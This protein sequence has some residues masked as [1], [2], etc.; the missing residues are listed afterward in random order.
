MEEQGLNVDQ[1]VIERYSSAAAAREAALCCPVDNPEYLKVIPR[2]VIAKDYGCGD[3]SQWVREGETVLDLGSGTGKICFIASQ[4][5]GAGGR[6]IGVDM[7][8]D[9]LKVAREAAPVVAERI[10]YRNVEFLKG[11]IDDLRLNTDLFDSWLTEHPVKS[12]ADFQE[13]RRYMEETRLSRPNVADESVDVVVS[14]CVLNLVDTDKKEALFEGLFRVL[15]RGGRAVISDIVCDEVVP[16]AMRQDP[17]LWSGCI[18]GAFEE[19]A[20]IEAFRKAGFYGIEIKKRDDTPWQVVEGYEFRSVTVI[21]YKGKEGDCFDH[22]EAV[23]YKG[24]FS[25]IDD[26]DGHTYPRGERVAVC[27]KTFRILTNPSGPY[28]D[29]FIAVSPLEDVSADGAPEFPCGH[30]T[31]VRH[32]RETKGE[33]YNLTI[34]VD[35]DSGCC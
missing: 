31:L 18:S 16:E 27:R 19:K 7:N 33:D 26:D 6:V 35:G 11:R 9:M 15:K 12:A 30:A 4:V 5:V 10:G 28:A 29:H 24:P 14:N 23:I 25:S 2:E 20:F 13:A 8:D 32:P 17:E 21:A 3:P 34:P 1:A 22:K